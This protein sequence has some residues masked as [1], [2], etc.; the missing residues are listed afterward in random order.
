MEVDHH[1]WTWYA[2]CHKTPTAQPPARPPM[3]DTLPHPTITST[4]PPGQ[5]LQFR[6]YNSR[7]LSVWKSCQESVVSRLLDK[8]LQELTNKGVVKG[9]IQHQQN[10]QWRICSSGGRLW[11]VS[12]SSSYFANGM[13]L[14]VETVGQVWGRCWSLFL[15]QG[16]TH[17]RNSMILLATP[18]AAL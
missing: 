14:I 16:F 17:P 7:R 13:S 18:H 2:Q 8:F 10:P 11:S 9:Q 12:F 1:H 3:L 6:T 5:S 4:S 15:G